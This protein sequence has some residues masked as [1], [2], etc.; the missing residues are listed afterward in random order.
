MFVLSKQSVVDEIS[1]LVDIFISLYG[2][3]GCERFSVNVKKR[4]EESFLFFGF[5]ML[6]EFCFDFT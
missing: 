3:V 5:A 2:S 1:E 6:G 4:E